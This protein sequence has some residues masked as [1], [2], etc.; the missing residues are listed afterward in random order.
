MNKITKKLLGNYTRGNVSY[1]VTVAG[2][3]H[4]DKYIVT[5]YFKREN[6]WREGYTI[7]ERK[8]LLTEFEAE[9]FL[10]GAVKSKNDT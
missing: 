10:T 1:T 4:P 2:F 7:V 3:R 6:G 8:R 5:S 9:N